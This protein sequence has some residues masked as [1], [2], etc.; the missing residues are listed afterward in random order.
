MIQLFFQ[1][2]VNVSLATRSFA[3]LSE[4]NIVSI[5]KESKAT[6]AGGCNYKEKKTQEQN[7]LTEELA[8]LPVCLRPVESALAYLS[9]NGHIDHDEFPIKKLQSPLE[10]IDFEF[11]EAAVLF[12]ST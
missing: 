9:Q 11:A 8:F 1:R 4:K 5:C 12:S 6:N 2:V 7:D 3:K 10:L